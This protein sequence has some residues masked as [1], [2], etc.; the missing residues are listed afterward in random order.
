MS[1]RVCVCV[2]ASVFVSGE[3][4]ISLLHNLS[5]VFLHVVHH[6]LLQG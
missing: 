3:Y 2:C 6:R 5:P 4:A 1:V